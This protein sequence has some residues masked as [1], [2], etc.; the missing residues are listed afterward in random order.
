MSTSQSSLLRVNGVSKR[1]GSTQALADV[2]FRLEQGE[3]LAVIGENGAGKSTIMKI[4]AGAYRPDAGSMS[5][6]GESYS[7]SSTAQARRRGIAM[8]FQEL[9]LAPDLSIEDNIMLGQ[10]LTVAGF[11]VRK[12]QRKK[13][14]EVLSLLGYEELDLSRIVSTL[15][16]GV[17]QIVE[18]ARA[19]V[20]DAKVV[21]FD[22]PTS[23]LG[24]ADVERL[25]ETLGRLK[26]NGIGVLYISHFLEEI[27]QVC[28]KFIV[29]RDGELV[30]E[31]RLT[32]VDD[33]YLVTTMV[34]RQV[35]EI[36]PKISHEIKDVILRVEDVRG[37]V[38]PNGVT[39]ELRRGEILGVA[40]LVGSGRTEF[41]R[42]LFG[43]DKL[44]SGSLSLREKSVSGGTTARIRAGF[45]FL[46][47]D[48]KTEGLAQQMSIVE[49][50]TMSRSQSFAPLGWIS[51]RSRDRLASEQVEKLRIKGSL[52]QEI[53]QLSGGNQQKVAIARLLHQEAEILLL[54]EP[55]RGID[56]GTKAEIY[57]L[58]GE[59]A[60]E[61]KSIIMI[62]S[63]LPELFGFCDSI[64]VFSR[65]KVVEQRMTTKWTEH[66][67]MAA[68]ISAKAE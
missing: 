15:P 23:S 27:R 29:L 2:S 38:K 52:G 32:D 60:A 31:G 61:G 48:R 68:A 12:S 63:Y 22:E 18:I 40:G 41:L 42:C 39:L 50:M 67:L 8:I 6:N 19:L 44:R 36:F 5:V 43:L 24:K 55:T 59:L 4:L 13:I 3:A 9:N 47:E 30:G 17:Q 7:P 46:S 1:F 57:R 62:S 45:G 56:V 66:E 16:V 51:F 65:G 53:Q 64:A 34:G 25:F 20:F 11:L 14:R 28:D 49:N 21:I 33:N 35:N 37:Q 26:K 58:I 54:D 10:E